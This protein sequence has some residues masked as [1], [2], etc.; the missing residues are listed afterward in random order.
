MDLT[1]TG[2]GTEAQYFSNA[3]SSIKIQQRAQKLDVGNG[4]TLNICS[5]IKSCLIQSHNEVM[6]QG[7]GKSKA[8]EANN[9]LVAIDSNFR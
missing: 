7:L 2:L 5:G 1:L 9:S 4:H 8:F 6:S 3:G